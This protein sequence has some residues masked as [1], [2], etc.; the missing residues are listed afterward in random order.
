MADEHFR[1][2]N[3]QKGVSALKAALLL[4]KSVLLERTQEAGFPRGEWDRNLQLH[5][6]NITVSESSAQSLD[7]YDIFIHYTWIY[8]SL[9]T[10]GERADRGDVDGE[11]QMLAAAITH[12][13]TVLNIQA[14]ASI[15]QLLGTALQR[16]GQ[17]DEAAAA[18]GQSISL[19]SNQQ[20][21]YQTHLSLATVLQR[22]GRHA[23]AASARESAAQLKATEASR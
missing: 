1:Q 12:A 11:R 18:L 3:S 10:A 6:R 8:S 2:D 19:D 15:Y 14:D 13:R 22:M 7:E 9:R 23:E 20:R 16:S 5:L 17:L 21:S 4:Q